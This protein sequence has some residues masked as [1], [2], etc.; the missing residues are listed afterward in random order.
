MKGER[1]Q[2]TI[3]PTYTRWRRRG[4]VLPFSI[5]AGVLV[6]AALLAGTVAPDERSIQETRLLLEKWVETRRIISNEKREWELGREL[7]HERIALVK[8]EIESLRNRIAEAEESITSADRLGGELVDENEALKEA[9]AVLWEYASDFERRTLALL[10]RLPD[11]IRERV[12]PLSQRVPVNPDE[13]KLSLSERFQNIVGILNEVN[14]FSREVTLVSEVRS[15]EGGAS[16]EV[17]SIYVGIAQGY[18]VGAGNSVAGYGSA[19]GD[20]W[21]WVQSDD[22]AAE[23]AR[24]IAILKNEQVASFVKL[25]LAEMSAGVTSDEN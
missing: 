13:S 6:A 12:R 19:S 16:A 17:T 5:V 4:A 11:P 21:I 10:R 24:A 25:P 9:A 1:M 8:S 22:A 2:S 18:F 7:L 14:R 20:G 15:L 3:G 23:I